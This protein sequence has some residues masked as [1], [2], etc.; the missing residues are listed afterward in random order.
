LADLVEPAV[1]VECAAELAPDFQTVPA[2][3]GDVADLIDRRAATAA[4]RTDS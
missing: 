3:V 4:P 1:S 2:A